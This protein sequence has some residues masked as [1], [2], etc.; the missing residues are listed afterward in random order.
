[1]K[2]VSQFS[3]YYPTR[4][5]IYIGLVVGLLSMARIAHANPAVV[6]TLSTIT[7]AYSSGSVRVFFATPG[8]S[9]GLDGGVS[10]FSVG[11]VGGEIIVAV[12][13]P[14]HT[15]ASSGGPT[16]SSHVIA[17]PPLPPGQYPIRL[18]SVTGVIQA[19][20]KTYTVGTTA[21][22]G[23][24][25]SMLYAPGLWVDDPL[26]VPRR[27]FLTNSE[28]DVNALIALNTVPP[29]NG[30][31]PLWRQA[32]SGFRAWATTGDAPTTAVPV[33]RFF[34]PQFS[35]HFYSAK[36]EECALLKAL[37]G[38]WSDEGTA[39]RALLPIEG[40]C[41]TGT[42]PVYRSYSATYKNHRYTTGADTYRALTLAGW[43]GE[44][45][46]FCSPLL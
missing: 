6:D 24:I 30:D 7:T 41:G 1:M 44:G 20:S 26:P 21:P 37:P 33:C 10:A 16:G 2:S 22:T 14:S 19:S 9:Y 3:A 23:R 12:I 29:R 18:V 43:Q 13:P 11:V 15:G 32:D 39:F 27:Y 42:E 25:Y 4:Q 36:P 46:A 17:I 8:D 28:A 31:F 45:V 34:S 35:T 38:Q 5:I 40:V